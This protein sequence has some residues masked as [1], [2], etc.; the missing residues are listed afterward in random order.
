MM[1]EF[2]YENQ[3]TNTFLVYEVL[4]TD[5]IDTMSLGMITNNRIEG[6]ATT[7]VTQLNATQYIKY[8][9]SAMLTVSQF[10]VGLVN[11]KR[12][13]GVFSGIVNALIAVEDYM[14]DPSCVLLDLN[15]IFTDVSTCRTELICLPVTRPN[16]PEINLG[17]FFKNIMFSTQFDQTENCDYVAKIIN[18]LNSTAVF[19]LYD[20]KKVL[21][22]TTRTGERNEYTGN[23]GSVNV[24]KPV[25]EPVRQ[26]Q[27]YPQTHL[28]SNPG[29]AQPVQPVQPVQAIKPVQPV[30]Q[31]TSM[32]QTQQGV[33]GQM[34]YP[35]QQVAVPNQN[36]QRMDAKNRK[37]V[38]YAVP[39]QQ[40]P[41]QAVQQT[42]ANGEKPM[43]MFHLLMHYNKENAEK[44]KAQKAQKKLAQQNAAA[45]QNYGTK[46]KNRNKGTRGGFD[47]PGQQNQA[48]AVPGQQLANNMAMPQ[49]NQQPVQAVRSVTPQMSNPQMQTGTAYPSAQPAV[50]PSTQGYQQQNAYAETSSDFGATTVLGG[51]DEGMTAVLSDIPA[52]GTAMPTPFIIR[53]RNNERIPINKPVFRIGKEKSFVD[54]FVGD[55]SFISRSHANIIQKDNRYFIVDNNS[56]NHTYVNGEFIT[57]NT[58]VELHSGDTFKLANEEFEFKIF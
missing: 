52:Q 56:R 19:S 44:Y 33:G 26:Q 32:P 5:T 53:V 21:D 34:N 12:L 38:G 57:S 3:G 58:E 29:G 10:F 31:V 42:V 36:S 15:Y 41:Q 51:N 9:V 13:I 35:Q 45:P 1:N 17:A 55:N 39:Q 23:I 16:Q 14:I 2:Y 25:V 22:E 18:Y 47:I 30:Q 27:V 48:F 24:Q 43:S 46:N 11:R 37:K 8:D 54:Y 7:I 49:Q 6:L 28:Q 20:F 50:M 40:V 4:P